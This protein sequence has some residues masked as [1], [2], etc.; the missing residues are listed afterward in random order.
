MSKPSIETCSSWKNEKAIL[1]LDLSWRPKT[2]RLAA[3]PP[4][5]P[6]GVSAASSALASKASGSARAW[7]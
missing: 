6:F 7:L 4:L 2:F 5:Q 3:L 1:S